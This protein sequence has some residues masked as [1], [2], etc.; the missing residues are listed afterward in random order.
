MRDL[1]CGDTRVYMELEIR[2]VACRTCGKVKRER[3][4]FLADNALYTKRFT[5]YV[6]R[7]VRTATIQDV[8][9][10]LKLDWHTVKELEKQYMRAQL[11]RAGTPGPKAIGVDEISIR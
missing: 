1:S 2:R 9:R 4:D 7:Q 8:A 10:E 11:K 3:L 6:G 5:Y